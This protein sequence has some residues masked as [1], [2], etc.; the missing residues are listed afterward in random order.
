MA[1]ISTDRNGRRKI[2]FT[3]A[4]RK[5]QTVRLGKMPKRDAQSIKIKVEAL[6]A[7]QISK[8][9]IDDETARWVASLDDWLECRLA[10]VGLL[11]RRESALLGEYLDGYIKSRTDVKPITRVKYKTTRNYLIE[12]FG[13][14]RC[15]RDITQGDADEWRRQ[16]IR[17]GHAENTI[18][19][20]MAVAKVFFNA[21]TRMKLI[22]ANPFEDQKATIQ[23][24]DERFYFVSEEEAEKVL[25]ACP[26]AEWR[27]IF[28][29]SRYGGLRCPSEH[30]ALTWGH[31]DWENDRIRVPSP[32]TEHH[33]GKALRTIPIF[34]ELR[35]HL[36]AVFDE[37][38]LHSAE[39]QGDSPVIR[40]YRNTNANLRTRL[41][42]IIRQAGLEPWPKLFQ[43]CRSTRE[44]ELIESF[45][46]HV[47]CSWIGN[48]E[49]VAKN[50]YLQVTEAHFRKATQN[51][52]HPVHDSPV[53]DGQK[54]Q[55]SLQLSEF[56]TPD[57]DGQSLN[58]KK[59]A[60][61]GLEPARP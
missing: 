27:L 49:A 5:R 17:K 29:L 37:C 11:R 60:E 39:P 24:N 52:T 36:E 6:L 7:A 25:A 13:S 43:N 20:H 4:K 18:R 2:Q 56:F 57:N 16:L 28:A 44:T 30:L 21:A 45:P 40:N 10:A 33:A 51:P 47:V 34:P 41:K 38:W 32:K 8:R 46:I 12:A 61:A 55:E 42:R 14:A 48:T 26:D 9:P 3:D 19:K 54:K 59:I 50:H 58:M 23:P 1:S 22:D 35:P 15:L 31:V 53:W